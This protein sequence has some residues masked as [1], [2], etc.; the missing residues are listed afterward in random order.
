MKPTFEKITAWKCTACGKVVTDMTHHSSCE[1]NTE[2]YFQMLTS[3]RCWEDDI[4][5]YENICGICR[6]HFLGHKERAACKLCTE[7]KIKEQS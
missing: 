3:G 7:E 6:K 4:Q 2:T 5:Q 1:E